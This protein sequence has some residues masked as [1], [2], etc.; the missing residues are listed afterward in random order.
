MADVNEAGWK[1]SKV[2]L[3]GDIGQLNCGI[4][5][6][7]PYLYGVGQQTDSGNYLSPVNAVTFLAGQLVKA[8]DYSEAIIF[9]ISGDSEADFVSQLKGVIDVLPV[10]SLTQIKRLAESSAQLAVEKMIIPAP[11]NAELSSSAPLSVASM[12]S[13]ANALAVKKAQDDA[14]G[15]FSLEK[16]KQSVAGF[17]DLRDG[18]LSEIASALEELRGKSANVWVFSGQGSVINSLAAMMKGIPLATSVHCAA[19]MFTGDDLTGIR[20]MIHEYESNTGT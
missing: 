12:R 8:G 14:A 11:L 4:S 19:V 13:A 3:S 6:A 2:A 10:P 20:G 18:M 1:Y 16:L 5:T 15:R 9:L 7:H 17:S